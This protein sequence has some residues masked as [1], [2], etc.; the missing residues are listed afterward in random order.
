MQTVKPSA[1]FS[2]VF[3]VHRQ[4]QT[5]WLGVGQ[6]VMSEHGS[7][8]DIDH[9]NHVMAQSHLGGSSCGIEVA[10]NARLGNQRPADKR[11]LSGHVCPT[12]R[13]MLRYST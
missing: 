12:W 11:K 7:I 8:S 4:P 13:R 9:V 2:S 6:T 5:A 3:A 10:F 1:Q